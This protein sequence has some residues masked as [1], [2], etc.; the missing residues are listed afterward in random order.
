M[1]GLTLNPLMKHNFVIYRPYFD[2]F[3][4]HNRLGMCVG[5]VLYGLKVQYKLRPPSD[6][7]SSLSPRSPHGI[8]RAYRQLLV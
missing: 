3:H 2:H 5:Y 8:S 4:Q 7:F 1:R 6:P